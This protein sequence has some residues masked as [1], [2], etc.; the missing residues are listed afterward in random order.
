MSVVYNYYYIGEN[1]SADGGEGVRCPVL[2]TF[3]KMRNGSKG[4]TSPH[5]HPFMEIFYFTAGNGFFEF[6]NKKTAVAAGD[7]V[8][9][10]AGVKHVQYSSDETPL[11][12][13]GISAT[14][15]ELLPDCPPD[16][17]NGDG[18][19]VI[20]SGKL[21]RAPELI[22]AI[23]SELDG[24]KRGSLAAADAYVKLLLVEIIRVLNPADY[25]RKPTVSDE[26]KAFIEAHCDEDIALDDLCGEFFINKSTLL[27]TFK[28][29]FG[30]SPVKY[31]N[32]YRIERAK[33][34]LASG[35]S[36]TETAV[37]VGFSNPVYFSEI[38]RR[39]TGLSPSAFKKISLKYTENY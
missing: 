17:L 8:V 18:F 23:K 14:G 24:A 32:I 31:L 3:S 30:V 33:K 36:V 10:G 12:Y 1:P 13:Y 20:K 35:A 22:D 11:T 34:L 6:G 25:K 15:A 39:I 19:A 27:H 2:L 26:V 16:G 38:F 5:T 4:E 21:K 29:A 28:A 7:T 37:S 9:V